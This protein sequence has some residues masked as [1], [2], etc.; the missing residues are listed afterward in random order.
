M[1]IFQ[2]NLGYKVPFDLFF[3]SSSTE[4]V[5]VTLLVSSLIQMR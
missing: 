1:A 3:T 5:Q 4:M 2:V